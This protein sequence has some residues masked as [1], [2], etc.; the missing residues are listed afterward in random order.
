MA[1]LAQLIAEACRLR[2]MRGLEELLAQAGYRRVAGVDEVGRGCLAGPVVAAAV[3]AD[4][5]SLVPGVDDSKALNPE[6]RERIAA[7][8]RRT[9]V[10]WAV[11]EVSA[12]VID[13]IN[14]LEASRLAM[15]GALGRLRPAPDCAVV[16]AVAVRGLPFPC[17]PVVRG[18]AASY[19]VACA[20][21]VA[22][23]AR[24]RLMRDLD[25]D[26]PQY[27]FGAHKG[28]A[29]PEHLRALEV[30]GPSPWH[31]LTFHSV[32]PR[33]DRETERKTG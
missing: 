19:A 11:A 1:T 28:Y 24:D 7:E 33:L 2:L 17:L 6:E 3:I 25:R 32:V 31:R 5:S 8:V 13:R 27:G 23:V 15:A 9:A 10:A 20:S 29:A 4:P 12:A 16:D 14:I 26:W 22:K 30:Y 18:D 21:I